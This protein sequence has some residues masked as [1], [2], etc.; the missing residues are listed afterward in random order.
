MNT[1][2]STE[3]MLAI[4]NAVRDRLTRDFHSY[5]LTARLFRRAGNIPLAKLEEARAKE[6]R[7]M[8]SYLEDEQ[9]PIRH[10]PAVILHS[11]AGDER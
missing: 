1:E 6:A 5:A 4:R 8:L 7:T 10:V 3:D 2:I 11:D 9:E